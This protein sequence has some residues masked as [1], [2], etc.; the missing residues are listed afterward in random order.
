MT[1]YDFGGKAPVIGEGAFVAETAVVLGDVELGAGASV[2]YGAVVRGDVFPIR[3]GARTNVQ[4][5]AVVHVTGGKSSTTIGDDVTVGHGAIVHGCKVGDACLVG[6]GAILLDGAV[7]EPSC[8][9][10]AG[11]LVTPGTRIRARSLVMG[12]PGKVVREVTEAELEGIL[13]SSAAYLA[14][15]EAHRASA[16]ARRQS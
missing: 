1:I 5:N 4:D 8:I 12:R 15:A 13:A 9:I 16:R 10:A 7:I 6:M 11:A 2:W 3:I 14:N